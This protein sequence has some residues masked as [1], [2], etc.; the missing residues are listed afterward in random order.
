MTAVAKYG[1]A[2]SVSLGTCRDLEQGDKVTIVK[3]YED[4]DWSGCPESG[5]EQRL[6]FSQTPW[7]VTL[8][9]LRRLKGDWF[10]P[11]EFPEKVAPLSAL[12]LVN[13]N[14]KEHRISPVKETF[15]SSSCFMA[16]KTAFPVCKR[17]G[18]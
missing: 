10:Y 7:T 1:A 13:L 12:G 17:L 15:T 4:L 8:H 9:R 18:I 3:R 11:S 2:P 5:Q 6:S 16:G 14:G